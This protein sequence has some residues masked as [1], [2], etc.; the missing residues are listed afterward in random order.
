[1]KGK[2]SFSHSGK[3]LQLQEYDNHSDYFKRST[4]LNILLVIKDILPKKS[5]GESI[6]K[7]EWC[8]E[9]NNLKEFGFPE[10]HGGGDSM[11]NIA[12]G[13]KSYDNEIRKGPSFS[14]IPSI[15][16]LSQNHVETDSL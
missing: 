1:M 16:G 7:Q 3:K 8:A 4:I 10:A 11:A 13:G 2:E 6:S 12:I 9:L 15:C 5:P 14:I